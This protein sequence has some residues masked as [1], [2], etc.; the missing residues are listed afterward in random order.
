MRRCLT[1]A[2]LLFAITAFAA[3]D[4]CD[5]AL[6]PAATLLLPYF[7]VDVN[8]PQQ[9][10]AQTIFT[11]QNTSHLP[12]IAHVTLW[13]DWGFAALDFNVFLTGYDVQGINL[14][15][16]LVRATIAPPSGTSSNV[17]VP[18]NPSAGS[19]PAF[20]DKNPKISTSFCQS[21][22]GQF[23]KLLL[24]DLQLIFTIGRG[25]GAAIPCVAQT[26]GAHINAIGYATIDVIS[27]CSTSLPSETPYWSQILY[28]NVL[29]GDYQQI[30][31]RD[32]RLTVHGGPLVH[33]RAVPEGT[34]LPHT[35]YE[36]LAPN[37]SDRRQPLPVAFAPRYVSGG[38]FNTTLRIWR[39][40][41]PPKTPCGDYSA[42]GTIPFVDIVRFDE[43]ENATVPTGCSIVCPGVVGTPVTSSLPSESAF[44]PIRTSGDAGGWL[45]LNLGSQAWVISS[46]FA[47]DI[48]AVD[49]AAPVL[50]DGCTSAPEAGAQIGARP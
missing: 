40:P 3:D 12:Q 41:P 28:D 32:G 7:E 47:T 5:I 20:N 44:F 35:F 46:M 22:P 38:V 16:V 30:T 48:G 18:S 8:S 50:V 9:S 13:T 17:V 39:E 24:Q 19:Q 27:L 34:T 25:N 21:L 36:H 1:I 29:T 37:M 23:P 2:A 4:G 31:P 11:I 26:G 49:V 33:L 14:Y 43:H 6:K 45:Y 42:N 10:A 15:D